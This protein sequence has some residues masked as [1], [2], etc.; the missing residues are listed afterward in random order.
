MQLGILCQTLHALTV[1]IN[2]ERENWIG[3]IHPIMVMIYPIMIRIKCQTREI[4]CARQLL[5]I[6]KF[7]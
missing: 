4:N 6:Y 2:A 3:D 5:Q 1:Q 7:Y